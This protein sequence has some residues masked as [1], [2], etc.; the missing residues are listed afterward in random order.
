MRPPAHRRPVSR[1]WLSVIG[2]LAAGAFVGAASLVAATETM[3]RSS[4]DDFC[5]NA[6]HSMQWATEAYRRSVHYSNSLGLRA[7]CADCHIPHHA[8]HSGPL[9]YLEVV[10]FKT[11]IG[12]RDL[13]AEMRGV[14]STHEKWQQE[15]PRLSQE[16]RQWFRAG[17]SITCQKCHDL[18]AFGGDYSEMTKMVH[19]DLLD[20]T[21][22]DCIKCHKHVSHVYGGA[23][24]ADSPPVVAGPE[25]AAEQLPSR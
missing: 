4:T 13:I 16:V 24:A 12:I 20:A 5:A 6:C 10:A 19:A 3:R 25:A 7:G 17:R 1:K 21:S 8:E 9:E 18:K 2:L 23:P 14:I 11:R 22:V 15:Q